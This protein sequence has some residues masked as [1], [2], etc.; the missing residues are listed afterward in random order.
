MVGLGGWRTPLPLTSNKSKASLSVYSADILVSC[1]QVAGC[2]G[3]CIF[4]LIGK[5][6]IELHMSYP[7]TNIEECQY[8]V[9]IH[10]VPQEKNS[11]SLR[12]F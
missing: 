2:S 10:K 9:N 3:L 4:L 5:A 7:G 12:L 1:L 8:G 11:V 6:I